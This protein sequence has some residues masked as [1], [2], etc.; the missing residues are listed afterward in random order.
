[1]I[2]IPLAKFHNPTGYGPSNFLSHKIDFQ[3]KT[4]LLLTVIILF[5]LVLS[6][7][8][9]LSCFSFHNCFACSNFNGSTDSEAADLHRKGTGLSNLEHKICGDDADEGTLLITTGDRGA[10]Q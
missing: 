5:C 9:L 1:M 2:F 7:L 6:C 3:N 4:N 8:V 10:T